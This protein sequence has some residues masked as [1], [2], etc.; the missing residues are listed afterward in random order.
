MGKTRKLR[1]FQPESYL[2]I[3]YTSRQVQYF[4][5]QRSASGVPEISGREVA[6]EEGEPLAIEIDAFLSAAQGGDDRGV[7]GADGLRALSAARG[8]VDAID[9]GRAVA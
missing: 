3:D 5:L 6:V 9:A 1:I 2:S 4:G 8:V 7:S